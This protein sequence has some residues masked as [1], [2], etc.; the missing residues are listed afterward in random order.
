[1]E[2]T[3]GPLSFTSDMTPDKL[4]SSLPAAGLTSVPAEREP[5]ALQ[6]LPLLRAWLAWPE[7]PESQARQ[8]LLRTQG[9]QQRLPKARWP[10][11]E[12]AS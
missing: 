9:S 12:P 6:V 7:L 2:R 5:R 11:C 1:M 4:I 10:S 8:A 3:L